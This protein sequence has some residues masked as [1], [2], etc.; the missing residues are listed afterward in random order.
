MNAATAAKVIARA[1][2][3]IKTLDALETAERFRLIKLRLVEYVLIKS[4]HR[5]TLRGRKALAA[6]W[7]DNCFECGEVIVVESQDEPSSCPNPRCQ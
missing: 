5:V 3:D 1:T 2:Q 7:L 4:K 6:G